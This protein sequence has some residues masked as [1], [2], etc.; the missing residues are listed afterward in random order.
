MITIRK[1]EIYEGMK[2]NRLTIIREIDRRF[3]KGGNSIRVVEVKCDCGNIKQ[4]DLGKLTSGKVKSCG[5]FN[6]EKAKTNFLKHGLSGDRIH[7]IWKGM[8]KRCYNEKSNNYKNYGA[9]GIKVCDS[10]KNDFMSFYK[11]SMENG[12][13]DELSIERIDVNG[14]YEPSNCKWITNNEQKYN[15][16]KQKEFIGVN[17]DGEVFEGKC[18]KLFAEE[19][20]LNRKQISACLNNRQKSHKGWIFKRLQ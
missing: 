18:I 20:D 1:T 17:P 9:R 10:W 13:N 15:T 7:Q 5:C 4:V 16:R 19:H 3:T 14:H 11:W 6:I 12:Y 2:F 8:K